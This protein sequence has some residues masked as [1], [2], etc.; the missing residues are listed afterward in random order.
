MNHKLLLLGLLLV[1]LAAAQTN[2]EALTNETIVKLVSAGVPTATIIKTIATA[3]SV[4]FRFL[5]GDLDQLQRAGVPD[6]VVKAMSARSNNRLTPSVAV[7]SA[8][9]GT[10]PAPP[11]PNTSPDQYQGRGMWDVGLEGSAT[12]P[13]SAVSDTSGFVSVGLGYFVS[14]GS[15]IGLLTSGLFVNGAQNVTLGGFYRYY[16]RTASPKVVP[17]VGAAAGGDIAHVSGY[18]ASGNFAAIGNAGIRIFAA[19]HVAF[20]IGYELLYEHLTGLGFSDST[21]SQISIGFAH[22]FGQ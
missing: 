5:P 11:S 18:G 22:V 3:D 20:E 1:C 21:S 2:P 9:G 7:S 13:H 15:E 8:P 6:D 10:P 12:I 14:R 16:F 4:S 19:R 17:F